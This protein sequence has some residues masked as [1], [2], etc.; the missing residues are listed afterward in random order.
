MVVTLLLVIGYVYEQPF[1]YTDIL[2][3][4]FNLLSNFEILLFHN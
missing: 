2:F 1:F 3:H 4:I